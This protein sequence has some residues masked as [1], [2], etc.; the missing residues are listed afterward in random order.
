MRVGR[1]LSCQKCLAT[2][3]RRSPFRCRTVFP[4]GRVRQILL[5]GLCWWGASVLLIRVPV[6]LERSIFGTRP[7][8]SFVA[9][10]KRVARDSVFPVNSLF[11]GRSELAELPLSGLELGWGASQAP[12]NL[13][14]SLILSLLVA[15]DGFARDC[16]LRQLSLIYYQR[17]TTYIFPFI[18]VHLMNSSDRVRIEQQIAK[19]TLQFL[20][21]S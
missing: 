4:R 14:F 1:V 15:G 10:P 8:Q 9:Q 12:A 11:A 20:A 5:P 6:V 16:M 18:R 17:L 13:K 21:V 19:C 7:K 3:R 2:C